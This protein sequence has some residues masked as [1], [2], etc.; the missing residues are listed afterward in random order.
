MANT[1]R[2]GRKSNGQTSQE[3]NGQEDNISIET[4]K[5]KEEDGRSLRQETN[6]KEEEVNISKA[7]PG[8]RP[9]ED[10]SWEQFDTLCLIHCTQDEIAAVLGVSVETI[11][12]ACLE[13]YS[14][15]F[16]ERYKIKSSMGKMSVRR[17]Q[18]QEAM[19][20]D[21]TMLKHLGKY[22]IGQKDTLEGLGE[23]PAALLVNWLAKNKSED[24]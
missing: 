11:D 20:G 5:L 3:T 10:F 22:W 7:K 18:Y 6:G 23:S 24:E 17:K 21:V 16:S 15:S 4:F 2:K 9:R 19:N 8:G 1:K 13:K 12:T 14:L